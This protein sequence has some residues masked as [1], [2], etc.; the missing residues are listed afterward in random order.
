MSP[1]DRQQRILD[2]TQTQLQSEDPQLTASFA[3][4]VSGAGNAD[5]PSA[6]QLNDGHPAAWRRRQL[7]ADRPGYALVAHLVVIFL[8]SMLVFFVLSVLV[9]SKL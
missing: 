6:E 5:M 3:A 7:R 8:A 1:R 4:F 2:A 9:R